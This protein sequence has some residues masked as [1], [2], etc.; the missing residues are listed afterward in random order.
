MVRTLQ[1]FSSRIALT[2]LLAILLVTS[3][4]GSGQAPTTPGKDGD[5][6]PSSTSAGPTNAGPTKPADT[7]RKPGGRMPTEEDIKTLDPCTLITAEQWSA[8][9]AEGGFKSV[10]VKLDDDGGWEEG[11]E[12]RACFLTAPGSG[13]PLE[14]WTLRVFAYQS[15]DGTPRPDLPGEARQVSDTQVDYKFGELRLV[16]YN[17]PAIPA[18]AKLYEAAVASYQKG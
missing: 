11:L 2:P 10:P 14:M 9:L 6:A 13:L 5:A 17:F 16:F 3:A 7:G 4:C 12:Q 1:S 8:A 15:D 18:T